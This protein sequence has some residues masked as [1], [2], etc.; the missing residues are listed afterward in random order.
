MGLRGTVR[1]AWPCAGDGEAPARRPARGVLRV[2]AV[3]TGSSGGGPSSRVSF[4]VLP[5]S[6]RGGGD[7][8]DPP[9][10]EAL[11]LTGLAAD[12]LSTGGGASSGEGGRRMAR[13]GPRFFAGGSATVFQCASANT[14]R[15]SMAS[16]K[17]WQ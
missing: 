11:A 6:T 8:R 14:R 15:S 16:S 4:G 10:G 2:A 5:V 13:S 17:S 1:L 7:D 9:A 12:A 3:F